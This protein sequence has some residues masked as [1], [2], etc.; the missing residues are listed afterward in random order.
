MLERDPSRDLGK[1]HRPFGIRAL[2]LFVDD[3]EHTVRRRKGGLKFIQN[4]GKFVDRSGKLS[5]I[6]NELRHPSERDKKEGSHRR[7]AVL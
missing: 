4:I 1:R 3:A 7:R 2:R 5:R 6:L